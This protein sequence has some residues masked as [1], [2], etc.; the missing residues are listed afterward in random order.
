MPSASRP[1]VSANWSSPVAPNV[2]A[3]PWASLVVMEGDAPGSADPTHRALTAEGAVVLHEG[4]DFRRALAAVERRWVARH[5]RAPD[6]AVA[7]L[8]LRPE[9]VFSYRAD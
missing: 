9:R 5:G 7:L 6:W 8:E 2:R 4:S 3:R 1:G